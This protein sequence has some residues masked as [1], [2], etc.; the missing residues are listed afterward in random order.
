VLGA[1]LWTRAEQVSGR[2]VIAVDGKA[3]RGAR[4]KDG[5]V[6]TWSRR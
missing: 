6:R 3:V 1:W 2:P 4:D 5:K